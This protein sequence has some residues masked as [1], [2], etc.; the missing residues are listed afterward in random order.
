V[1]AVHA[2]T[3][4]SGLP[5]GNISGTLVVLPGRDWHIAPASPARDSGTCAGA[6]PVDFEGDPRPSGAGCDVGIDEIAP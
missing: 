1:A 5:G 3:D 4:G 2:E 6:L